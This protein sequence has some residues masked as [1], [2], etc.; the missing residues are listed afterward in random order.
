VQCRCKRRYSSRGCW[1]WSWVHAPRRTCWHDCAGLG[2]CKVPC[3]SE[4]S[5]C[6]VESMP[7]C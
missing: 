6:Q 2:W 4:L 1:C 7:S 5:Q 3:N